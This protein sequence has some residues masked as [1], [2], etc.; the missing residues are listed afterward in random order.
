MRGGEGGRRG[1]S[2]VRERGLG[3]LNAVVGSGMEAASAVE[4]GAGV[5]RGLVRQWHAWRD[6]R[7]N[8]LVDVERTSGGASSQ[9]C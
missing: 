8:I 7:L 4:I 5:A 6:G 9:R 3:G 2:G 1:G